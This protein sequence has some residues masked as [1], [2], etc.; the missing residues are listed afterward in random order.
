MKNAKKIALVVGV[1]VVGVTL[2]ALQVAA[3]AG[4]LPAPAPDSRLRSL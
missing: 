4:P 3:F 1:I 2:V